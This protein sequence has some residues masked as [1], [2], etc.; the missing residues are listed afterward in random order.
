MPEF[1]GERVIPG[2][3]DIDLF[4][5]HISRYKFAGRLVKQGAKV[6]DLG[7]GTGYGT[8]ELAAA[9]TIVGSDIS[10][11]AVAY[12]RARYGR[13][14]VTFLEASCDAL[15]L[16]D[17]QFDLITAFEL[18]EHLE[19]WRGLLTEARRL[20]RPGGQFVVST[21]NKAYYAETRGATGPNPFHTHEFEY[22]EFETALC[23][24][25]PQ[26]RIWTQNHTAAIVFAPADPV[27]ANL[28]AGGSR[29]PKESHFFVAVCSDAPG[30][31]EDVFAWVPDSANLLKARETHIAKLAEELRRKDL[32][33]K[34]ALEAHAGLQKAHEATLEELETRSRWAE[35]LND[36]IAERD[37]LVVALHSEAKQQLSWVQQLGERISGLENDVRAMQ[38]RESALE[39]DLALR[40][41]WA[42]DLERQLAEKIAHLGILLPE[43][44]QLTETVAA[45][46]AV[47]NGLKTEL[48]TRQ[49]AISQLQAERAMMAESR[50]LRLGRT[51]GVGP[52]LG[53]ATPDPMKAGQ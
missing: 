3:V 49:A 34:Q 37:A 4:N 16:P 40:P 2:L 19:N 11:E 42:Q 18:I 46:G 22:G 48:G 1:T 31:P 44:E 21:P 29:N 28:N 35:K 33:L 6:L 38:A 45:S 5:E 39:A 25:F 12:A 27:G 53:M 32:W 15:P 43:Y 8:A 51:L 41:G 14:G 30:L 20:L 13:K 17:H 23:E 10:A 50:W 7:C 52:E 9:A 47:I 26:V 24:V 36:D